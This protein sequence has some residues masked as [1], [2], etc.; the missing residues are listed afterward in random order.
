MGRGTTVTGQAEAEL[1]CPVTN[2]VLHTITYL[3]YRIRVLFDRCG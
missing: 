1:Q 2:W 3:P